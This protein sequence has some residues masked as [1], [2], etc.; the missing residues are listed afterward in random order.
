MDHVHRLGEQRPAQVP[1]PSEIDQT[2]PAQARNRD[3]LGL[4]VWHEGDLVR[5]Q[6]AHPDREPPAVAPAS[7]ERQ[8][9]LRAA[10]SEALHQPQHSDPWGGNRSPT[11]GAGL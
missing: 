6:V 8:Q 5:E 11:L 7:A 10:R 3:A 2:G 9:A 1:Q 4:Q